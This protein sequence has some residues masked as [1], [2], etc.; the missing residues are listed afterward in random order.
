MVTYLLY[1]KILSRFHHLYCIQCHHFHLPG[2]SWHPDL[3]HV[4]TREGIWG[5]FT[6]VLNLTSSSGLLTESII[7]FPDKY[8]LFSSLSNMTTFLASSVSSPSSD[9][10]LSASSPSSPLYDTFFFLLPYRPS[11]WQ[12]FPRFHPLFLSLLRLYHDLYQTA[13]IPMHLIPLTLP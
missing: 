10:F 5:A 8:G 3:I 2:W 4:A 9:T 13:C 11:I 1:P 7:P 6:R 12:I